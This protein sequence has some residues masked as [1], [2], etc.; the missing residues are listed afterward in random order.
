MYE[1]HAGILQRHYLSEGLSE[2]SPSLHTILLE[3]EGCIF[4]L[5][6]TALEASYN[7]WADGHFRISIT[8]IESS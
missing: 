1:P 3:E 7:K 8:S 5:L 2:G 4:N 6:G